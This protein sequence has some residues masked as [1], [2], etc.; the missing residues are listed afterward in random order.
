VSE[1]EIIWC[2]IMDPI[3]V[4]DVEMVESVRRG[5]SSR[6][7]FEISGDTL[8]A[9]WYHKPVRH[10]LRVV[11]GTVIPE[12]PRVDI[13]HDHGEWIGSARELQTLYKS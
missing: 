9:N 2:Q 3:N 11:D 7:V 10:R 13:I 6:C 5:L 12:R 4:E 1:D 8:V